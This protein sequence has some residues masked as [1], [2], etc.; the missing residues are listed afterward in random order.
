MLQQHAPAKFASLHFY[1]PVIGHF[2]KAFLGDIFD[3]DLPTIS[4]IRVSIRMRNSKHK[5]VLLEV[6]Q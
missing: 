2:E 5:K 1:L 6:F 3:R 4:L